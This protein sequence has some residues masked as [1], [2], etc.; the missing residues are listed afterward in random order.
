MERLADLAEEFLPSHAG[1]VF[2]GA[3]DD[4]NGNGPA[5]H[6][7]PVMRDARAALP[8]RTGPKA[9]AATAGER[10]LFCSGHDR[11]GSKA[12]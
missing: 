7:T 11:D 1:D 5:N 6:V 2:T 8:T 4:V 10:K 9:A 3:P 12:V